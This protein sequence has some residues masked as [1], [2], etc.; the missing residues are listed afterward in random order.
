LG[1][2]PGV[3][4]IALSVFALSGAHNAIEA[5]AEIHEHGQPGGYHRRLGRWAVGDHEMRLEQAVDDGQIFADRIAGV[6][7]QCLAD[8]F[9]HRD[10]VR[11]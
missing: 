10:R 8:A 3:P 9:E 4:Q 11:C 7:V 6:L 5:A 1:L 2:R